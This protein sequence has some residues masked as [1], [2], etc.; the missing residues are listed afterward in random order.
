LEDSVFIIN[1]DLELI[2]C[3]NAAKHFLNIKDDLYIGKKQTE[4]FPEEIAQRNI[5]GLKLAIESGQRYSS[6]KKFFFHNKETWLDNNIIPLVDKDKKIYAILGICR[7]ITQSK[8]SQLDIS[9]SERTFRLIAEQSLLGITILHGDKII[10]ANKAFANMIEI[11]ENDLLQQPLQDI[12]NIIHPDDKEFVIKQNELK[13]KG[14]KESIPNYSFR[15]ITNSKEIK[16]LELY[17]KTITY[18]S[19]PAVLASFYDITTR[20][21][22]EDALLYEQNIISSIFFNSYQ[23]IALV[24]KNA[25]IKLFSPGM[26]RLFGFNHSE[27]PSIQQLT[28][29][30]FQDPE[31]KNKILELLLKDI[32][33]EKITQRTF[34]FTHKNKQKKWC[35]LNITPMNEENVVINGQD[36]TNEKMYEEA[37][38]FRINFEKLICNISNDFINMDAKEIDEGINNALKQIGEFVGIDRSSIYKWRNE[39]TKADM[40]YEWV[41]EG[42]PSVKN[43]MQNVDLNQF[44]YFME[45]LKN[46]EN[47]YVNN[48]ENL[49]EQAGNEKALLSRVS[50]QSIAFIPMI[51]HG[52]I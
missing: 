28:E 5:T 6:Q 1:T 7:D 22:T 26:T 32:Q 31:D 11:N 16:W 41:R 30:I 2:Y 14:A 9:K 15:I 29:K 19:Q 49:P 47:V 44:K 39:A 48:I 46:Y 45:K 13:L 25:S 33:S 24:G 43:K 20:K 34:K 23:G 36:I 8:L 42:F 40:L 52:R 51:Y 4:L 12:L 21:N 35:K 50:I 17:S 10:Y 27:I 18:N 37:L 3:N 38:L